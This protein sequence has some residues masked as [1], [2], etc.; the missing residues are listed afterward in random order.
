MYECNPA[1]LG[2]AGDERSRLS[3]TGLDRSLR[4]LAE[5]SD[6]AKIT[7]AHPP[8]RTDAIRKLADVLGMPA[9]HHHFQARLAVEMEMQRREIEDVVIV[10]S[11]GEPAREIALLMVEDIAQYA[12]TVRIARRRVM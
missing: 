3:S 8:F 5:V 9:Q 1:A 12:E 10:M 7:E 6:Q 2:K 4:S 11:R